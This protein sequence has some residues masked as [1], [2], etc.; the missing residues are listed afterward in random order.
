MPGDGDPGSHEARIE[1]NGNVVSER[2]YWRKTALA[3]GFENRA[4]LP[5]ETTVHS[6]TIVEEQPGSASVR[7]WNL[8]AGTHG[9]SISENGG[10]FRKGNGEIGNVRIDAVTQQG[11]GEFFFP[12]EC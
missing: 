8:V 12:L 4:E 5:E 9:V 10:A 2:G 11:W 3:G 7:K 1:K 6:A